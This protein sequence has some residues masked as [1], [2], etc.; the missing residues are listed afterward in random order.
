MSAAVVKIWLF[1]A[2]MVVL[3]SM[4]LVITPPMVS[5]AQGQ[6]GDVQQQQVLHVAGQHAAL[7]GSAQWPRTRR[8]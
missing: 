4:S 5:N 7:E 1:L 2:G 3:R 8:G 6:G